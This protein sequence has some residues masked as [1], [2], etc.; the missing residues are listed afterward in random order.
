[1]GDIDCAKC[2]EPWEAYGV[3]QAELH[4]LGDMSREQARRFSNG[5]GCPTC[6]FGRRCPGCTGTG[7]DPRYAYG[8][9]RCRLCSDTG[10]VTAR[11]LVRDLP[12]TTSVAS[13]LRVER[14]AGI[15]LVGYGPAER[16]IY[17]PWAF[18]VS[19]GERFDSADGPFLER[20]LRCPDGCWEDLRSCRSCG[21]DGALHVD[22]PD[23]LAERAARQAMAA[24]D[25][26]PYEILE[27]R[28]LLD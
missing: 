21:G 23:G 5:E 2:G 7:R 9:R 13:A 1:M 6:D 10:R 18:A 26:D 25:G 22:D 3:R 20:Y 27:R 14:P 16:Q 11:I 19:P 24:S 17:E 12:K 4:D 28:G 8:P 15:W